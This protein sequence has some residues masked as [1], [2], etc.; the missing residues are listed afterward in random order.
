MCNQHS[1]SERFWLQ[2]LL[3]PLYV[4]WIDDT[5]GFYLTMGKLTR[6]PVIG[7]LVRFFASQYGRYYH[8]GRAATV[9]EC[10]DIINNA[11]QIKVVDCSCRVK[12]KR[13]AA[14]LKTCITVNTGAGIFGSIKKGELI[15]RERAAEIVGESY[16]RG[17]IRAVHRCIE[18]DVY[19]ICN[20]CTCCCV[21]YRL[22]EE[23]DIESAVENGYLAAEIDP[24]SCTKCGSCSSVCPQKAIHTDRFVVSSKECLGCGLCTSQCDF[25]AIRMVK[26]DRPKVPYN[27]GITEKT[28]MLLLFTFGILPFALFLKAGNNINKILKKP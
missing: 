27:P 12:E 9:E 1:G 11:S 17:L 20:C 26:R 6:L 4:K 25:G 3:M 2:K 18:P 13:C 24:G 22:R 7:G 10:L 16:R 28:L 5:L 19:A 14:P 21:P 15:S 8:G 23:F